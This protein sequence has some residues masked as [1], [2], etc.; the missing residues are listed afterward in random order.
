MRAEGD[1]ALLLAVEDLLVSRSVLTV[2]MQ[3]DAVSKIF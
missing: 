3:K 1:D 2:T